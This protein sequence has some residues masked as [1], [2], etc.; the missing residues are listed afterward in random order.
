MYAGGGEGG[1]PV[2]AAAGTRAGRR[3]GGRAGGR[4]IQQMVV[5]REASGCDTGGGGSASCGLLDAGS[6]GS[7]CTSGSI[8]N[9]TL[10]A[11]PGRPTPASRSARRLLQPPPPP[12]HPSPAQLTQS[13][14]RACAQS[15]S[16]QR[17]RGP[18]ARG[19]RGREQWNGGGRGRGSSV[20]IMVGN[21]SGRW[22]HGCVARG[23]G[24]EGGWG[25]GRAG[26]AGGGGW[27]GGG[28]R[29]WQAGRGIHPQ[30]PKG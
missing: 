18:E 8:K 24:Q 7:S 3:A 19:G 12:P 10:P 30:T 2:P 11:L 26:S 13:P 17:R 6:Y 15:C 27:G 4:M 23:R 9:C 28:G 20:G 14:R 5:M 16:A 29:A 1:A 25:R 22:A 21:R